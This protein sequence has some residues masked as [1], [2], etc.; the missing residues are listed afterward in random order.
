M[1]VDPALSAIAKMS[2][3]TSE[4]K[5]CITANEN[6]RL[7]MRDQSGML[8]IKREALHEA[9]VAELQ[10]KLEASCKRQHEIEN[11]LEEYEVAKNRQ[12]HQAKEI[13]KKFYDLQKKYAAADKERKD[14]GQKVAV[15]EKEKK[16]LTERWVRATSQV[17]QDDKHRSKVRSIEKEYEFLKKDDEEARQQLADLR[18]EL[19]VL[20][21]VIDTKDE[22]LAKYTQGR[23][24]SSV[25]QALNER[26]EKLESQVQGLRKENEELS[27]ELIIKRDR[28]EAQEVTERELER[29]SGENAQMQDRV[30][31]LE[32]ELESE[33]A[34]RLQER[35]KRE[36]LEAADCVPDLSQFLPTNNTSTVSSRTSSVRCPSKSMCNDHLLGIHD[37]S[38]ATQTIVSAYLKMRQMA[39]CI[40]RLLDQKSVD[41][42]RYET[43]QTLFTRWCYDLAAAEGDLVALKRLVPAPSTAMNSIA[44]GKENLAS[45]LNL[46]ADVNRSVDEQREKAGLVPLGTHEAFVRRASALLRPSSAIGHKGNV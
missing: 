20:K 29:V 8:R 23:D 7:L 21:A 6:T 33:K 14:L 39:D 2:S 40:R 18:K 12:N 15:L 1:S 5:C 19:S 24:L 16:T 36:K 31:R 13:S 46:C 32:A 3:A 26:I 34:A 17:K 28:L 10:Q 44:V 25:E 37:P 42:P 38:D 45:E 11:I 27:G 4:S 41:D 30:R 35:E 43:V 22:L 9:Q